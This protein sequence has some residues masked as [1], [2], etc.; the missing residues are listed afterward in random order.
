MSIFEIVTKSDLCYMADSGYTAAWSSGSEY[1]QQY[2]FKTGSLLLYTFV[3]NA[4]TAHDRR[5]HALYRS[6]MYMYACTGA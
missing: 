5:Q 1:V 6:R 2:M 3:C 4:H